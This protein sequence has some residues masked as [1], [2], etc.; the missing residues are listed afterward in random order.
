MGPRGRLVRFWLLG[1]AA[2]AGLAAQE[3]PGKPIPEY[4]TGDEC[5]FCHRVKVA[6]TW[7][8][9]PHARTIRPFADEADKHGFP[10][11]TT[12]VV[13]ARTHFRGL[14]KEG[15]GKFAF[16]S[17]DSKAWDKDRFANRCGG[18]HTTAFD[19]NTKTFATSALDCY[20]CHGVANMD[21]TKNK[22]LMWL[23]STHEKD[24][25]VV[26]SICAQCHLRGG[27][28]K[29]T[30]LPFPDNFVVGE[31]LFGNFQADLKL[32]S[33]PDLNAGDRHVYEN[34][35]DVLENQGT[36]TCI[37]CHTVHGDSTRKHRL[38]LTGPICLECHDESGPK[39]VVKKYEVHSA[40]CE[41]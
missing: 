39:K 33:N 30:G 13:G 34:V 4:T 7:Q 2:A 38:V 23:S 41:Y 24:P 10:A 31:N 18:C 32:A 28:S 8:Q 6:D 22:S 3:H 36:V 37:N 35:R 21:H 40:L 15:Y 17:L 5:L 9:N 26:T 20:V 29:T 25:K 14:K 12:D 27:T 16:L 19:S 11:D 1:A